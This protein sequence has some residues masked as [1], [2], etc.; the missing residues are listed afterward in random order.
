MRVVSLPESSIARHIRD[1][2]ELIPL[3]IPTGWSVRWNGVEAR[4][5]SSGEFEIND[6]EDLFWAVRE[7]GGREITLDGGYYDGVFK[8]HVL[9]PDWD[10]V[11]DTYETHVFDDFVWKLEIRLVAI[12]SGQ[13]Y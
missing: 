12:A 1:T 7:Q 13:S 2:W 6:S 8:I 3:R 4:R 9:E 10:H 5:L 11:T